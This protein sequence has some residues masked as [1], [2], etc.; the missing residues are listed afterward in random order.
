MPGDTS[1]L[2]SDY[3]DSSSDGFDSETEHEFKGTK[4]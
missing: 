3:D 4:I 1:A 2:M